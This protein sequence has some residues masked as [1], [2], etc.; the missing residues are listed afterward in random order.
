REELLFGRLALGRELQAQADHA[1]PARE[2][3]PAALDHLLEG[4]EQH[5]GVARAGQQRGGRAQRVLLA[6]ARARAERAFEQPYDRPQA[7]DRLARLVDGVA[8]VSV[9]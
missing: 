3:A 4:L 2:A 5:L 7:L 1:G 9:L 6:F 8:D